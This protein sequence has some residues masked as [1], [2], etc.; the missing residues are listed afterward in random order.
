[1]EWQSQGQVGRDVIEVPAT[2][3]LTSQIAGT[4][5]FAHDSLGL[6]LGDVEGTRNIAKSRARVA[7]DQEKGIAMIGEQ[8]EVGYWV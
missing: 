4:H 3:S 1:M 6:A 2:L 8:P 5:Q 7:R